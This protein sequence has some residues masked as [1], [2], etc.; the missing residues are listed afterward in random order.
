M[1]KG[2]FIVLEGIDGSGKATQAKLLVKYLKKNG[3]KVKTIDFPQYGTKSAGLIEEYLTGKY[4]KIDA[5]KA[6]IFYAVDRYDASFKIK[7]WLKEGNIVISDRYISSNAGHQGGKLNKKERKKYFNWLYNLEY[8][9]FEI[10]KPKLTIILKTSPK[11]S[12]QMSAQASE[13]KKIYLGKKKD[14]HEKDIKHLE[15]SL[16]AYLD[17][18]KNDPKNFKVVDCLEKNKMISPKEVHKKIIKIL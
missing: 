3:F 5:Y 17:L 2:S 18:A 11:L 9:L 15:R 10:P 8:G 4:G 14:I 16:E 13:R 7:K 6:S 1:K 12:Y